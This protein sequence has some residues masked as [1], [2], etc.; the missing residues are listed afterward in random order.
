MNVITLKKCVAC[1]TSYTV[2]APAGY[3][4][5]G[6]CPDC[7]DEVEWLNKNIGVESAWT[8]VPNVSKERQPDQWGAF[9]GLMIVLGGI[10]CTSYGIWRLVE[11]IRQ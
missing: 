11:H 6:F 9:L 1:P 2:S 10:A 7:D 4:D 8:F 5:S 3:V